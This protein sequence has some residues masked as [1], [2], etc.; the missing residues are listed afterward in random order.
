[1]KYKR[2]LVVRSNSTDGY[3][4][5]PAAERP[6]LDYKFICPHCRNTVRQ[7]ITT[8]LFA[9]D[10][11]EVDPNF[12]DHWCRCGKDYTIQSKQAA[13]EHLAKLQVTQ[14]ELTARLLK[15]FHP[16]R[17]PENPTQTLV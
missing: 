6:L 8:N 16:E 13:R 11:F 14:P 3:L 12:S 5:I 15:F 1:M 7:N 9:G 4:S 17:N 2:D 10:L